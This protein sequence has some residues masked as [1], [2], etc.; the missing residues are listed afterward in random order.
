[1]IM[2]VLNQVV[3]IHSALS[4]NATQRLKK[5]YFR[6]SQISYTRN[7]QYL[8]R[9]KSGPQ[10]IIHVT[11]SPWR[12]RQDSRLIRLSVTAYLN[13]TTDKFRSKP[14]ISHSTNL[15]LWYAFG[16][17]FV[18]SYELII[19]AIFLQNRDA[20]WSGYRLPL[21][22]DFPFQLESTTS[23][24]SVCPIF[25]SYLSLISF[26]YRL[27]SLLEHDDVQDVVSELAGYIPS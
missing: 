26:W 9:L 21:K 19:T 5:Q 15:L 2:L 13:E 22:W 18:N 17:A 6:I 16:S 3:W 27:P 1:M 24:T 4:I 8:A 10:N 11:E 14:N 25:K 7:Q 23:C 12:I 20:G